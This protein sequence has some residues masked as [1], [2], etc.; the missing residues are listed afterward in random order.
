VF[1]LIV[2]GLAVVLAVWALK[3]FTAWSA[4]QRVQSEWFAVNPRERQIEE[5]LKAFFD[6]AYRRRPTGDEALLQEQLKV[7]FSPGV[8]DPELAAFQTYKHFTATTDSWVGEVRNNARRYLSSNPDVAIHR[9]RLRALGPE[10]QEWEA[11]LDPMFE[12]WIEDHATELE[13]QRHLA[14]GSYLE[15]AQARIKAQT[16]APLRYFGSSRQ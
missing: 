8:A 12:G 7:I 11:G 2:T 13:F 3:A 1:G 9:A 14:M 10:G 5:G 16:G 4:N 6:D 15:R